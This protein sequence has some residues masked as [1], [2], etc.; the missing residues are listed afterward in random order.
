MMHRDTK[1]QENNTRKRW[2][3]RDRM[4]KLSKYAQNQ[5][6]SR[7]RAYSCPTAPARTLPPTSYH[8][9]FLDLQVEIKCYNKKK[10]SLMLLTKVATQFLSYHSATCIPELMD[11]RNY[12][13]FSF[14]AYLLIALFP[15]TS[16]PLQFLECNMQTQ[17]FSHSV[18]AIPLTHRYHVPHT[19]NECLTDILFDE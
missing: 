16:L 19:W 14:L 4:Y 17:I 1:K 9:W 15:C 6:H 13:L 11:F 7:Y 3:I 2:S 10:I 5:F 12:F 18:M 8:G